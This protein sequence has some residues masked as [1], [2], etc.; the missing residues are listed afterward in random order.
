MTAG[1]PALFF[2]FTGLEGLSSRKDTVY[3]CARDKIENWRHWEGKQERG[4]DIAS[5]VKDNNRER[6]K[7]QRDMC[8][9]NRVITG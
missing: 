2:F 8:N 5:S 6:K 1:N 9:N 7:K 3:C 4:T